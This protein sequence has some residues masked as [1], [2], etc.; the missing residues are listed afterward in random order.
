M[1][2]IDSEI[3][4]WDKAAGLIPAIVQHARSGKVLMLGYVN[5]EA[6]T[7][8]VTTGKVW[9]YSRSKAR[10]WMKGETSGNHLRIRQIEADCD[11]DCLLISADPAGPTC[12]LG[13]D[14]C[15][16]SSAPLLERLEQVIAERLKASPE[17]SYT[18]T[19]AAGGVAAGAK[20]VGEE[21]VELALAATSESA[22]RVI[23][24]A[25]DLFYHLLVVLRQREL[26]L[27]QVLVEL[28]RRRRLSVSQ[29]PDR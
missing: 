20:K 12:H 15:F 27:D 1:N 26:D 3:L 24:E 16:E 4:A 19:L 28:D 22:Q 5:R 11:R 21:G 2:A 9:F 25:A 6:L 17:G 18:A 8:C 7:R 10:L 29:H 13:R 14:A 23:S